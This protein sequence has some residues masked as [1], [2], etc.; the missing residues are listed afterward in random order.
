MFLPVVY[1]YIEPSS[2]KVQT[3]ETLVVQAIS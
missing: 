1:M 3:L 2:A